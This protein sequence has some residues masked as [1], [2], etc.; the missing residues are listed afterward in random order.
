MVASTKQKLI[1]DKYC[2]QRQI[3]D[4]YNIKDGALSDNSLQLKE[5]NVLQK[6]DFR[7]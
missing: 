5:A 2:H 6:L 1:F 4:A 7:Y 3:Q